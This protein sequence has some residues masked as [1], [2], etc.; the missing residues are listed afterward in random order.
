MR[1]RKIKMCGLVFFHIYF[2]YL[3]K[4]TGS[5]FHLVKSRYSDGLWDRQK[6]PR[7]FLLEIIKEL[8]A[9]HRRKS[10]YFLALF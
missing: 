9:Q 1:G 8:L 4:I 10:Q 5:Y 2:A 6:T 7:P 3:F